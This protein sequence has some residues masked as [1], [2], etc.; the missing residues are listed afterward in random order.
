MY[1]TV[2]ENTMRSLRSS[3]A[4]F[5]LI[6]LL[7]VIAIILL[8]MTILMPYVRGNIDK[9]R[10]IG[11]VSHLRQ[12]QLAV[13]RYSVDNKGNLPHPCWGTKSQLPDNTAGWLYAGN[14]RGNP[15][16]DK[17]DNIKTGV[18]WPYLGD[19]RVYRC[20]ADPQPRIS[21]LYFYPNDCWLLTSYGMNGSLVGFDPLG[22]VVRASEMKGEDAVIW[23]QEFRWNVPA[24]FWDGSNY[25]DQGMNKRHLDRGAYSRIDGSV[26]VI[27]HAEYNRLTRLAD[28]WD[29]K[30]NIF[31]NYPRTESGG[32]N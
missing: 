10:L 11:C 23:E 15:F 21:D 27:K 31:W 12:L 7:V 16:F 3:R 28:G 29:G 19:G 22:R 26:A 5:T 1:D 20:P 30:R 24:D 4:G 25:P 14:F 13:S 6:E 18:L 17:W 8:L 2:K 9:A 32:A